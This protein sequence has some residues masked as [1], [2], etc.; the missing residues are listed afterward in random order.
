MNQ[1]DFSCSFIAEVTPA[2]AFSAINRVTE[3]WTE[4]IEGNTKNLGDVFTIDFGKT[5]LTMTIVESVPNQRVVW[6]VTDCFIHFVADN[7][8][9]KDT[10][11]VW[12]IL[13]EGGST[14]VRLTHEGLVPQV[15]CYDNCVQG[16]TFYVK[17]SIYDLLT[18]GKGEPQ[19]KRE[20]ETA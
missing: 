15:E 1:L 12:E 20:A 3:W 14:Q 6:E 9:W 10:R 17:T 5:F 18:K 7:K 2:A 16:W 4:N 19:K 11:L 13:P 8:E